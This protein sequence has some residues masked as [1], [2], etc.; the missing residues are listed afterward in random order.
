MTTIFTTILQFRAVFSGYRVVAWISKTGPRYAGVADLAERLRDTSASGRAHL[1]R[2]GK[3]HLPGSAWRRLCCLLLV[4]LAGCPAS[5]TSV[6]QSVSSSSAPPL[7]VNGPLRVVV[8]D[9][10]EFAQTLGREWTAHSEY[11]V[12]IL[13]RSE[14][15]LLTQVREPTDKVEAD[16][17][18]FPSRLLGEL[19]ERQQLRALPP[20]LTSTSSAATSAGYNFGD[21]LPAISRKEIR[22]DGRPLA[23]PLGTPTFH[24]LLRK[25]L[26]PQ[27]PESWDELSQIVDGLRGTL[28]D[29]MRPLA[30]P[31]A[32]DW[33]AR[34][35]LARSAAYLYSPSHVSQFFDYTTMRPRITLEPCIRALRDLAA[36]YDPA[37]DNLDPAGVFDAF[38]RGSVAMAISWPQRQVGPAESTEAVTV[39]ELPGTRQR[40]NLRSQEWEPLP[41]ADELRRIPLLGLEGRLAA[42]CRHGRNPGL[43]GV[44]LGWMGGVEQGPLSAKCISSAP[45]RRSHL[46]AVSMWCGEYAAADLVA[47]YSESI[48]ATLGR[49]EAFVAPRIPGQDR[50]LA[51]L[52]VWIRKA[53][54][55]EVDPREALQQAAAEWETITNE[56][57]RESQIAAYSRSLGIEVQ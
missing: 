14:A 56:L 1:V 19:A 15:E 23:I 22:W 38:Q 52:S 51:S 16:V 33:V 4:V 39:A 29:D 34:S 9:D 35:F 8:L 46:S 27:P 21:I 48:R 25:D 30:E 6:D 12:E 28:S 32:G 49:S 18:V 11:P 3:R 41:V 17:V 42:V 13:S 54:K 53:L 47:D 57:G 10:R 31:L 45:F 36:T 26:V 50:Y 37:S 40:F 43:A 44:F 20:A 55:A 2:R 7:K 24:L 5:S